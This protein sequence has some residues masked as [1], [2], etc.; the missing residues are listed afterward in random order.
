M[1]EFHPLNP[2]ELSETFPQAF[3][4][5]TALLTAGSLESY[6]PMVIGWG[7]CGCIWG[8]PMAQ[9]FVRHSRYT[10]EFMERENLFSISFFGSACR[11]A[12]KICGTKSGRDVDKTR[13]PG[14]TPC[15]MDGVTAFEEARLILIC[16]KLCAADLPPETFTDASLLDRWY[17]DEDYHRAYY[18]EI[19]AAYAKQHG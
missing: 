7:M 8:L 3:S 15:L 4:K 2:W 14:L 17:G 6:N 5:E 10:F 12:L 11:E 18:G 13:L 9:V 19:L 16:R 1:N